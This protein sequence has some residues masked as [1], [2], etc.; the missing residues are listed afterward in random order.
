MAARNSRNLSWRTGPC[1]C[2][3]LI[4]RPAAMAERRGGP[5][6]GAFL[7]ASHGLPGAQDRTQGRRQWLLRDPEL[8]QGSCGGERGGADR[9]R[10]KRGW[11][12]RQ[13]RRPWAL[14]WHLEKAVPGP[15]LHGAPGR[16]VKRRATWGG[17]RAV[18]AGM[19]IPVIANRDVDSRRGARPAADHR[20]RWV[21]VGG[22][23]RVPG[24]RR[25]SMRHTPAGGACRSPTARS[26]C[27]WRPSS[28]TG[29]VEG[30]GDKG[31]LIPPQNL[32]GLQGRLLARG[33]CASAD[34]GAHT[35]RG[36]WR[37]SGRRVWKGMGRA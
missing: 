15:D 33:S 20:R 18:K 28:S 22:A 24:G 14:P 9:S 23:A 8:G 11:V 3:S 6:R 26:D 37:C 10:S 25:G 4:T 27:S 13:Q 7:I 30:R 35:W 29:L 2:K 19:R 5:K 16:G 21:M 12:V 34:G 36:R 1:G 32:G 17:D 31:C